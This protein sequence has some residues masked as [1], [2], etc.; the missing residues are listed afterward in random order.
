MTPTMLPYSLNNAYISYYLEFCHQVASCNVGRSR[1]VS[2]KL[3]VNPVSRN[4]F[5]LKFARIM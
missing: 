3:R 4:L 5:Q 2:V 1:A